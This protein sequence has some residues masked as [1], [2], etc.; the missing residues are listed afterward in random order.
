MPQNRLA[1]LQ[2]Q[3]NQDAL[4]GAEEGRG[5]YEMTGIPAANGKDTSASDSLYAEVIELTLPLYHMLILV[6]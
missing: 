5:G 3:R 1:A 4:P 6:Y 2:N